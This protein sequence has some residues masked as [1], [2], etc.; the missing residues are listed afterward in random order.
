MCHTAEK[1]G[2]LEVNVGRVQVV[3]V[4]ELHRLKKQL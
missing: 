1:C 4:W 2:E 3:N